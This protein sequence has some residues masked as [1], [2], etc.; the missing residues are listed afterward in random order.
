MTL[1][2]PTPVI[3][4]DSELQQAV[5]RQRPR[6]FPVLNRAS[7]FAPLIMV[8]SVLPAL[9]LLTRPT[10][11]EEA[12]LWGL[13]SLA[14]MHA[15]TVREFLEPGLN[16]PG[17]PLLYQPP[18]AAWLNGSVMR[19]LGPLDLLS[20]ALIALIATGIAIW[21][22]SR[23]A[24]RI[25]G[26]N[27]ALVSALL[28]CS[29]PQTLDM[30]LSPSNGAIGLC[31]LLASFF[32]FQRHLEGKRVGL[33]PSLIVSGIV[34]GLA[35][36]AVGSIALLVPLVFT[37]H[38][39][40]QRKTNDADVTIPSWSERVELCRA[41]MKSIL[42]LLAA[43]FVIG[44]WWELMIVGLHGMNALRSWWFC[45]PVE[46]LSPIPGGWQCNLR[47]LI[48]PNWNEWF[49]QQALL[50]S[51]LVVG[52]E[53]GWHII[54]RPRSE[55]ERR[56]VQLLLLW[57]TFAFAGRSLAAMLGRVT[58]VNTAIWNLALLG[59]TVLLAALGI[60]AL[61]E[62]AVSRRGEFCLILLLVS[63]TVAR[64]SMSWLVG[65]TGGAFAAV[66]LLCGPLLIPAAGRTARGWTHEGWRQILQFVLYGSLTAC[67]FMGLGRQRMVFEDANRLSEL[68]DRLKD[69]PEVKR[70]SLIGSNE[71]IPVTLNYLLRCR[72]P[73]A[74]M[75]TTE[76]WDAGLVAAMAMESKDPKS[77]FLILEWTH[78]DIRLSATTNQAWQMSAIGTPMRLHG[79]RLSMVLV[80]PRT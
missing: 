52:L 57:W 63:L 42:F 68:R 72:W 53:R 17:Q 37:V 6:L 47:P 46:C 18:L 78:R 5:T 38:A 74:E 60:G 3:L 14:V 54:C 4:N 58:I 69:F 70:I 40:N 19:V 80:E 75:S 16:E 71:P 55:Q 65:L 13:R 59:P 50:I 30:A 21:L 29:H 27:T 45:L 61:I 11:N 49:Q 15:D 10:L 44:G 22:T 25:G 2:S 24:W 35:L 56:R 73:R 66:L 77:K 7:A 23:M 43:G 64:I 26:A 20:P 32:G 34:W 67:L 28:M 36:L 39:M 8:C 33:T 41:M 31:L 76:G 12:S 1:P 9:P 51:W 79:R 62:R 48:Q